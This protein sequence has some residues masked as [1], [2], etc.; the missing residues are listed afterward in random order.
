M[1]CSNTSVVALVSVG[2]CLL[3]ALPGCPGPGELDGE[4]SYPI[5][6][7]FAV[8]CETTDGDILVLGVVNSGDECDDPLDDFAPPDMGSDCKELRDMLT[9]HPDLCSPDVTLSNDRTH[10]L[11][12]WLQGASSASDFGAASADQALHYQCSHRDEV[13]F[14]WVGDVESLNGSVTVFEDRGGSAEIEIDV[15]GMVGTLT[16]DVCR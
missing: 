3:A 16:F 7:A 10:M 11:Q 14:Y 12:F 13:E 4:L 6:E 2:G 9:D 1:S 5:D 8:V 15:E